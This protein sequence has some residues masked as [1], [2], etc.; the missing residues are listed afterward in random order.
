VRTRASATGEDTVHAR[1]VLRRLSASVPR[2]LNGR[3]ETTSEPAGVAA[4]TLDA[5]AALGDSAG[6]SGAH[7]API[8]GFDTL[9]RTTV[10]FGRALSAASGSWTLE[11]INPLG[12]H[13]VRLDPRAAAWGPHGRPLAPALAPVR[14][15]ADGLR[16]SAERGQ[17]D[18]R[19]EL[20]FDT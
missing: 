4:A 8:P 5:L 7:F 16:I 20:A 3:F 6:S 2:A 1:L 10:Q 12:W 13:P 11:A 17:Y 18:V 19:V 14:L 15:A 9:N